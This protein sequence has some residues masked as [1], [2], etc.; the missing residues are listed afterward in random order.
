MLLTLLSFC[1][2]N[3]AYADWFGKKLSFYECNN[4]IEMTSCSSK[5]KKDSE[6]KFEFLVDKKNSRV[7]NKSYLNAKL[8]DSFLYENCKIFNDKNWDCTSEYS[9]GKK[10]ITHITKMNDGVFSAYS[11]SIFI[12]NANQVTS[13]ESGFVCA[14]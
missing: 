9:L 6:I 5:C 13:T 7:M 11:R 14:K 10:S 12:S 1:L 4:Q 3:N 8:T 2:V